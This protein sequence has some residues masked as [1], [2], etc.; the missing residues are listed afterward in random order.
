MNIKAIFFDID[1]TLLS[2]KTHKVLPGTIEAF[3][4]LHRKGIRTFI[5]SGRPMALIPQF[6]VSFDGYITVNGGYCFVGEN[7]VHKISLNPDDCNKWLDYIESNNLPTMCFTAR[8][9]C[10]NRIDDEGLALQRELGFEMPPAK[11][12]SEM[13]NKEVYQFIALQTAEKD[14]EIL[15]MLP[16]CRLPRWH[17][18]FSDIIPINSSKA[19]GIGKMLDYFGIDKTESMAF[20]DG[21]NDIEML[22]YVGFGVAMGNAS[23]IVKQNAKYVTD[24]ADS[25]GIYNALKNLEII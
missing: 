20:G 3:E 14:E 23:N 2:Y 11:S 12:I 17:R 10:L 21:E 25:E 19:V 9:M 24:D 22:N 18:A 6:P 13:R 8:D 7:I 15:R 1:G 4:I 16:H 5:S